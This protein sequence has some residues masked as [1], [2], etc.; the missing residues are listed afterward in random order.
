[1]QPMKHADT[2]LVV[3]IKSKV[4]SLYMKTPRRTILLD[5]TSLR[6][7][8]MI[9]SGWSFVQIFA[10]NA[11]RLASNLIMT[12]LLLPEAFGLMALIS[13]LIVAFN[14]FTDVGI[15]RSIIREPDGDQKR[16][17]RVAWV[18]KMLRGGVIAACVLAVALLI[19]LLAPV[20][21]AEDS[22]YA[23]PRLPVLVALSALVPLLQGCESTCK[24]L[25]TRNM[26]NYRFTVIGIA[27]QLVG[28]VS[29][30]GFAQISPTVWALFAGMVMI[31]VFGLIA[32]H[33]FYPGPRMRLIWDKE[34]AARLWGYG[35]FLMGSSALTFIGRYAD[36]LMLAGFLDATTFGLYSI[37]LVWI[38]A[39]TTLLSRIA[40]RSGFPAIAEVVRTRPQDVPRLFRKYQ[41][42]IDA[43]CFAAFLG[44]FLLG[45]ALIAFLYIEAY[46][47][48][49][50]FLKI[51]SVS[52]L[53]ARFQT[54]TTLLM[55]IG[56]SRAMMIA[57]GMQAIAICVALPMAYATLGLPGVLLAT[58]LTPLAPAPYVIFK[59]HN[60]LGPRQT[61]LDSIVV[62]AILLIGGLVYALS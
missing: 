6:G 23:D 17:L 16:F 12:R 53:A 7:R 45:E 18:A 31:N 26:Q 35:K 39:G 42:V 21:A 22:V 25:T 38:E 24:E 10:T 48:A 34:I 19:W 60:T 56:D 55:N 3:P 28:I 33:L 44:T 62:L 1:M 15:E 2:C 8:M 37:A 50:S 46:A 51:L 40:D 27:A 20:L 9:A 30:L 36:R 52:F 43:A 49:G 11:L 59:L 41:T 54:V 5:P 13:T 4:H 32:T 47:P 29:M 14:L 58:A 57:S 61:R